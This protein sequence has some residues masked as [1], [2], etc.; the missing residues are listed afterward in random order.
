VE[1]TLEEKLNAI[2]CESQNVEVQW[3]N[4]KKCVLHTVNDF[5][6]IVERRAR[7]L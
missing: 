7:K 3:N 1:D 4:I 6:G 2:K 5:V